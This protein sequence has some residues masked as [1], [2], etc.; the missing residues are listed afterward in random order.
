MVSILSRCR[1]YLYEYRM[2]MTHCRRFTSSSKPRLLCAN[3][4]QFP[5]LS[6]NIP[7]IPRGNTVHHFQTKR[8]LN[9]FSSNPKALTAI[10]KAI[11][12]AGMAAGGAIAATVTYYQTV[13]AGGI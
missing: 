6:P 5:P 11:S 3:K 4:A 7:R 10:G 2:S 9:Y 1:H 13:L 8:A 12:R